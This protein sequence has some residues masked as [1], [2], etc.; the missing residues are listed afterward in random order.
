MQVA[1]VQGECQLYLT[2]RPRR[3][4]KV[5]KSSARVYPFGAI[6]S[7]AAESTSSKISEFSRKVRKSSA[8]ADQSSIAWKGEHPVLRQVFTASNCNSP[9]WKGGRTEALRLRACDVAA[10]A[11]VVEPL[12]RIRDC[13][14]DCRSGRQIVIF[15]TRC[16][17]HQSALMVANSAGASAG[18]TPVIHNY[19]F[20][21]LAGTSSC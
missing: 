1:L 11:C 21:R 15:Q 14:S 13:R 10:I 16:F 12:S 7:Y 18:V 8:R 17:R 5:R 20:P 4:G 6:P 3:L 2:C 19:A 9:T